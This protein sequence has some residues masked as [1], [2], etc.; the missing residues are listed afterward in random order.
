[1]SLGFTI[2]ARD[3]AARLGRLETAHGTV[4]TP[5]FM[6]VGTQATV[7][8]LTVDTVRASGARMVLGNT[9]HLMIRPGAERIARLGG[10]HGFM[11]WAGP[12]LTDSGGFQVMSL[13]KLRTIEEEGVVFRAHTDGTRHRLTPAGAVAIQHRLG[14]D[15][16]MV[17]DECTPYPASE[18]EAA[19]AMRR[20]MR[21][22][23]LSKAAFVPRPGHGIFGIVQGGVFPD[24][25]AESAQELVE[26]GFD[27]Y[28]VGGLAVG[29]G[30]ERMLAVL[31]GLEGALPAARPRYL[32]G[33]GTPDDIVEAVRRGIDLFDCVLPTRSGRTARAYTSTGTLNMRNARHAEDP[34]PVDPACACPTCADY[35]RAYL[36]HLFRAGE[37]LGPILLSQHN[38]FFY[39]RLMADLRSAIAAGRLDAFAVARGADKAPPEPPPGV[40]DAG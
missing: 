19:E 38:L 16:T 11:N 2:E 23:A 10:L 26:T 34:A 28:A 31:D 15:V 33:V 5:A 29:E 7:K 35:S 36:H 13:A 24:L 14:S 9:Y 27:G 37:M 30:Q 40:A 18:A 32:M 22:A 12:I 6:P 17:L 1:M 20:S 39:Q 25:R 8:G 3:G 4:D 21:W